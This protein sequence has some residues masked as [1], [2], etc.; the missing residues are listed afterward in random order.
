MNTK[1][2]SNIYSYEDI[3]TKLDKKEK[4]VFDNMLPSELYINSYVDTLFPINQK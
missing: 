2:L 1:V 3:I 4:K